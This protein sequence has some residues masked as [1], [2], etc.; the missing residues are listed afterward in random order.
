MDTSIWQAVLF[1]GTSV[2]TCPSSGFFNNN[3]TLQFK[4]AIEHSESAHVLEP[5][6]FPNQWLMN[7]TGQ[8]VPISF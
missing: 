2:S 1:S 7:P 4:S 3:E 5:Q 8:G 6:K